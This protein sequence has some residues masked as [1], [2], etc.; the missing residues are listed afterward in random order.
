PN[1]AGKSTLVK[2]MLGQLEPWAGEV[3]VNGQAVTALPARQRARWLS[4]VPQRGGV[5]FAFS[6]REVVAMGR[7]ASAGRGEDRGVAI[8]AALAACD[9]GDVAD[10]VFAELSGGQQQRVLI[11]RAFAQS[12]DEGRAMLLDEP[13]SHLDLRHLH[14]MMRLMREQ[15]A[16]GL[17]VLVVLHDLNL[18]ARYADE[19]WLMD[20]GCLVASGGWEAV[21]RPAVLEPV[22]G[23]DLEAV[24][25]GSAE[26]GGRPVFRVG[27]VG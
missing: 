26:R 19:V 1:A 23:L 27:G 18:A 25:A 15:A 6:V 20:G 14:G 5:Q 13:G 4:Y 2:L 24:A 3:S 16:R 22:Y 7:F 12:A 10:R 21:L 8:D 11:A 9:L 17:A